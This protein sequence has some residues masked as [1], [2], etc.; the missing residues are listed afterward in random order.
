VTDG[1][2]AQSWRDVPVFAGRVAGKADVDAGRAIFA[3]DETE[4]PQVFEE[5]LPQPVIWTD[6]EADEDF[7]ALIVQ[8]ERHET[9]DGEVLD[10]LGLLLP[11]GETRVAFVE[12]VQEVDAGDPEWVA[13]VEADL[14]GGADAP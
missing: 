12:D 1:F 4:N 14:A 2:T 3:L 5:P 8:A 9:D 11:D 6:E 13:L 7:A 10:I